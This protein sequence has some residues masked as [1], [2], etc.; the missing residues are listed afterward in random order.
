MATARAIVT[1]IAV[2]TAK[3]H[4]SLSL[5]V[6]HGLDSVE[7]DLQVAGACAFEKGCSEFNPSL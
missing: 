7:G 2:C 6:C 5:S 3:C 4:C 1:F